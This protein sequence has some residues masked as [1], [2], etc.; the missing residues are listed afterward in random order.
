MRFHLRKIGTNVALPADKDCVI[1][2]A[3][4]IQLTNVQASEAPS[5]RRGASLARIF[6]SWICEAQLISGLCQLVMQR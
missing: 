5:Q 3:E 4:Q 1:N 6:V 2:G